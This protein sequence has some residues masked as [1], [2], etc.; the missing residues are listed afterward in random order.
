MSK[1][2]GAAPDGRKNP[3]FKENKFTEE[4][5]FMRAEKAA[6]RPPSL[7]GIPKQTNPQ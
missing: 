1:R 7:N 4:Q 2:N 5:T 3:N 6:D